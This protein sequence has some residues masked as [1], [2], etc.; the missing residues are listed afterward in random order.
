M[1]LL[2]NPNF[3]FMKNRQ[4]AYLVSLILLI[5]AFVS[6]GVRG[7]NYG[8]DFT[9]GTLLQ[10]QFQQEVSPEEI[11]LALDGL[12]LS[13]SVIQRFSPQEVVIRTVQLE[14]EKRKAVANVLEENFGEVK[15]LRIE[16]VG[17][18]VGADLRRM[19]IIALL[20]AILGILLY[21]SFRFEFR[22]G[23]TSIAALIH[24][25]IIV[26]GILSLFQREFSIPVLAAILTVLGYSIN[27]TIVVMDRIRE[28]LSLRKKKEDFELTINRSLNE[29]LSRTINTSLTTLLPILSLLFLGGKM[30]Q[31]FALTILI[32]LIVGTYSS[33]FVASALFV[34]WE[35]RK[36]L[37]R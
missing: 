19:G 2:K 32:G 31:D 24:D 3:N 20:A 23:V 33:I 22:P 29:I 26:V 9:G 5:V 16:E 8:I 12:G 4:K 25:G 34:E 10:Y 13:R 35:Q 1:E 17:P 36:P 37:R 28:N 21:V 7:L 15:L 18:S 30:L 6:L 11:R 27:D 14:E